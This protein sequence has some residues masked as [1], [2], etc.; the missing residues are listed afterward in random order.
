[1]L[2][3]VM[4][5]VKKLKAKHWLIIILISYILCD[6]FGLLLLVK[7]SSYDADF[8]YP[9]DGDVAS[10]V[11][12]LKS[13]G[14]PKQK[15][16]YEHDYFLYKSASDACLDEDGVR[17]EQL[18]V[19]FLVKS[20]V[21]HRDRRDVIRK[22]W[23]YQRRFSDVPMRTVFLLGH[24]PDDVKLEAEV[25]AEAR[26]HKDIVQGSFIDTYFNN[27]IKTGMG[28]R[29]AVEHCPKSRFYM[30]VDDDY[31]VSA[32]N[33]LRF[34][35]NPV[36]Y[37]GYLQED[38]IT[39]DE[40]KLKEQIKSRHLNQ[41]EEQEEGNEVDPIYLRHLNQLVDFDLPDDVRLFTGFV[42]PRSRP[43]RH[44]SSKWFVGLDEYPYDFWPPY[45]TAGAYVLSREALIDMYFTSYYTK[46]F[47]FDDIWLG[48]IARKANVEPFH[49]PEFH[50]Y[51]KDKSRVQHYKFVVASHGFSDPAGL[52]RFW[53][54]QKEAGNA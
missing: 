1:M 45:V 29:W 42:F 46:M 4:I 13:G 18:R 19:T 10:L 50:F 20:A 37:P 43:H 49:C 35:R 14:K 7:Q 51:P 11:A 28:L 30:F 3:K 22:T 24:A 23:G 27:T 34:L 54:K 5:S 2:R 41:V 21:S 12:E 25:E 26:E 38:V 52:L 9:Y 47:R 6:Y 32:R 44:K 40:E 53:Q 17:Y 33:L 16:V 39:F 48:L 15:P 8:S 36:N 31:Y